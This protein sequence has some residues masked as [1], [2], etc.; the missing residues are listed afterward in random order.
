M[1]VGL[2]NTY[3]APT[4]WTV[5]AGTSPWTYTNSESLPLRATV[6]NGTVSLI[7]ISCDGATFDSLGLLAGMSLLNP[8]DRIR[9]TWAAVQPTLVL[10]PF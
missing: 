3:A 10:N 6:N 8:G 5:A 1:Y 7:E 4:R 9:I 2:P